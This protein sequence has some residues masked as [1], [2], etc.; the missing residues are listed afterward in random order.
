MC[1]VTL[2]VGARC[3]ADTECVTNRCVT[4]AMRLARCCDDACE[5]GC[6]GNGRCLGLASQASEPPSDARA[7]TQDKSSDGVSLTADDEEDSPAPVAESVG[8]SPPAG[9]ETSESALDAAPAASVT[10]EPNTVATTASSDPEGAIAV[11]DDAPPR[12]EC[13]SGASRRCSVGGALGNCAKGGQSCLQGR[14]GE[15]TITPQAADSCVAGDDADCDGNPNE[16]CGC[17]AGEEVVCGPEGDEGLCEFGVSSC[18]GGEMSECVGAVLPAQRDCSSAEDHD[19]D[20]QRDNLPD[21]FCGCSPGAVQ[22]CDSHP[23]FDGEG[24]CQSGTQTCQVAAD[25]SASFGACSGGVAPAANDGCTTGDDANCNG[26]PNE[27]C[28]TST[29]P[30]AVQGTMLWSFDT[31]AQ[32]WQLRLTDPESLEASAQVTFSSGVGD[33]SAGSLMVTMPFSGKNQKI[34]FNVKPDQ[35]LDARGKQFRAR[36]MLVSGLS[37]DA[38]APGG[39]KLFAKAGNDYVYVSGRWRYLPTTGSW[40][41]VVLDPS[42]P[43]LTT[44]DFDLEDVREVGFELRTFQDTTQISPAVVHVD[45]ITY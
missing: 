33:P 41:D 7:T 15:C 27:G 12:I 2:E 14:W 45:S 22:A 11:A 42:A 3:S 44:G 19:C 1:N 38:N 5:D 28:A 24:P 21:A 26:V 20:G 34:E 17:S 13:A 18:S 16:G 36:V 43:D 39:I 8:A 4:D 32:G 35:P 30:M 9:G 23:G 31:S 6:D 37:T 40:A 25:G 10:S 29:P